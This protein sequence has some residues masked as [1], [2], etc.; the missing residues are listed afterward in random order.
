M[1]TLLKGFETIWELQD[2]T[3]IP[4]RSIWAA[5][6]GSIFRNIAKSQCADFVVQ[7]LDVS[8]RFYNFAPGFVRTT[9]KLLAIRSR[10][11]NFKYGYRETRNRK[12]VTF[13]IMKFEQTRAERQLSNSMAMNYL[14][15]TIKQS[16]V[17]SNG[18]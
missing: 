15:V 7:V 16:S 11:S 17:V 4:Y 18:K 6:A 14:S 10:I 1:L 2:A 12:S 5:D 13:N 8:L 3:K 9:F